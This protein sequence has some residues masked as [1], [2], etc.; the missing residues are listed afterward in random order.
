MI[1]V[2]VDIGSYSIKIAE[3]EATSRSYAI[4]RV[5]EFP[6]SL[7]LT[8][9]R[10]IEIIDTLR[11]LFSQYDPSQT[12]FVFA[13]PQKSVSARLLAFP[14]RE[15]FKIQ[16]AV[17]S[18]LEDELP[19]SQED[20]VFDAKIV[21][22]NGKGADVLTMA[23]PRDR[24]TDALNMAHDCGV[25]PILISSDSMGLSNLFSP[26][27]QPPPEG[28]P[29]TQEIPSPR[30]A[31]LILNIGHLTTEVLVYADNALVGVRNIDWGARNIA[32]AI[33]Q[34][35]GLNYLQAMR[36]LQ[37][38]GFILL[39]KSQGSREQLAFSQAI[40]SS[41]TALISDLRLKM[42]ELQSEFH[43]QWS[44]G[45]LTGGGANL[46][47]LGNFLTQAFQIPFNRYKQ[48]EHHPAVSFETN[49]HIE[50]VS[51]VAIGLALEGLKR[52][53]N[54]ATNFL[55]DDL[56]KQSHTLQVLWEQWGYTAQIVGAAFL[57]FCVYAI[58]RDS[59]SSRLLDQSDQALRTQAEAVAGIKG[60]NASP[61]K[62]QK[63]IANQ[64]K[65][66][67]ARKQAEKIN[68]LNSALDIVEKI[69][70]SMPPRG[71]AQLEIK[72]ISIDGENAEVH[73]YTGS[74]AE[75]DQV[76][77]SLQRVSIGGK[78]ETI[79]GKVSAPQGKIGFGYH[80]KVQRM[81]G[82]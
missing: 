37:A 19:F 40:E 55:K 44:K 69:S 25:E 56:A 28:L 32:D 52:P 78:V 41:L 53:R 7:D 60:R 9:D 15:R 66:D 12:Q 80:F 72:R 33:G 47:N 24:V 18:Q 81:A 46:R 36:E 21:R 35:Y 59:L 22:Y 1:S 48:F 75:R 30:A 58:A 62:I 42:L 74:S 49:T 51:G 31:D 63:F 67:K 5:L 68:H 8:K 64:E 77:K 71:Q 57:I 39:E 76:F 50:M 11:T 34:K 13:V 4:R 14:F 54:P 65:I 6:L 10:K 17:V 79:T 45:H 16:K 23:V 2:G 29:A 3:I 43:L 38:K 20:A 82:G 73:G 70:A 61:S 26:F 27:D